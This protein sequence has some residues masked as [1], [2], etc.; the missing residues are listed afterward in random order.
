MEDVA[1]RSGA[2]FYQAYSL[3]NLSRAFEQIAEELRQQYAISYYPTNAAQD[4]SYR[5][6]K[7]RI[8]PTSQNQGLIVRARDGY[9][10][11]S[12]GKN[13]DSETNDRK[14]PEIKRRTFAPEAI[15]SRQE[16]Q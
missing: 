3:S 1:N 5:Q 4:G 14:R 12:K 7:V 2:R 15:S 11:A 16:N 8:S 13:T 10:A 9:R 6:V